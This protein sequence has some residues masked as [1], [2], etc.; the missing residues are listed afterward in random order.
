[1]SVLR[2]APTALVVIL[3]LL[4]AI[5]VAAGEPASAAQLGVTSDGLGSWTFA[6]PGLPQTPPPFTFD[7]T[8]N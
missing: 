7:C 4:L 2:P 3:A 6:C 8:P 1:M 5:T